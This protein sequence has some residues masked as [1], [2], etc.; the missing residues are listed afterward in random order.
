MITLCCIKNKG[1]LL[2]PNFIVFAHVSMCNKKTNKSDGHKQSG[3]Q[4]LLEEK[5]EKYNY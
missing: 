1:Q 3:K 4:T 5:G 2:Q